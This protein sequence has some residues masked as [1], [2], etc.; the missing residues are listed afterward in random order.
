MLTLDR[1]IQYLT[2]GIFNIHSYNL[3]FLPEVMMTRKIPVKLTWLRTACSKHKGSSL[4]CFLNYICASS[5]YRHMLS[6]VNLQN[7]MNLKCQW[8]DL[9]TTDEGSS[10]SHVKELQL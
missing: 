5:D 6:I 7:F 3:H 8:R 9:E 10:V 4:H 2:R 1:I